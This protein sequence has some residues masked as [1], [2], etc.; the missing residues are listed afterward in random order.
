MRRQ[1]LLKILLYI[2]V[3]TLSLGQFASIGGGEGFRLYLFDIFTTIFVFYGLIYFFIIKRSF[4]VPRNSFW[5]VGFVLIALLSW[6]IG[7]TTFSNLEAIVALFYLIRFLIYFL[8]SLIIFNMIQKKLILPNDFFVLIFI[9]AAFIS[10]VGFVQLAVLPDFTVLDSNL[11]WDPHKN[12]LASTFFDPNFTGGFLAMTLGLAIGLILNK[13]IRLTPLQLVFF[14]VIPLIALVLTFSRSSWGMF[15]VIILVLGMLRARWLLF[16]AAILMFLTYFA[17][18]RVQTRLSGV[19]DPADSAAFR[20]VSWK[21]T[22]VIAKDNPILGVN[23]FR[24]AQ[25]EYGFFDVGTQGGHAGSGSDSS[26]LL[27]LATTGVIGT[28]LFGL[29]YLT[30]TANL[31]S[32]NRIAL[33]AVLLG[34]LLHSQFVNS[35]FYPQIMFLWLSFISFYSNL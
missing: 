35:L 7:L 32:V 13:E 21:N 31:F 9:S 4:K 5:F 28:T 14:V 17:I 16:L 30:S 22:M 1:P 27:I 24:Y 12:R 8:S 34:L 29:G 19:T 26:L 33:F 25:R 10:I 20:L 3:F 2:V 15:A 6:L 18:P 11:G 23:Y